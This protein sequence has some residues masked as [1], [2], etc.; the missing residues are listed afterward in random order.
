MA[1]P[2]SGMKESR[3]LLSSVSSDWSS[4]PSFLILAKRAEWLPLRKSRNLA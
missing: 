2:H 4:L 1:S 3:I